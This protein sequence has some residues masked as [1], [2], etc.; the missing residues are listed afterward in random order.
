MLKFPFLRHV[1]VFSCEISLVCRL[2][3]P[4]N[5]CSS[6]FCFLVIALIIY[7]TPWEFFRSA[8]TD[9]F[10]WSLSDSTSH[11][12]S[13]TLLSI[14]ADLNNAVIW[15]VSTCPIIYESLYIKWLIFSCDLLSLYPAVHFLWMWLSGV[16]AITNSNGDS[17]SPWNMLL[18]IFTSAKLFPPAVKNWLLLLFLLFCTL[19]VFHNCV[20][21]GI[22][23]DFDWQQVSSGF[24]DFSL[25]SD[26][27]RYGLDNLDS[28]LIYSFS[29]PLSQPLG[30]IPS[31]LIIIGIIVTLM[32]HSNFFLV[33]CQYFCFLLFSL[34][35]L[36]E[37]QNP[38]DNNFFFVYL[39]WGL[40][41]WPGLSDLFVY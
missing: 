26:R 38:Q 29:S 23:W 34:S 13:K 3:Y 31:A 19:R 18:W 33:F 1:K 5:C 15:T 27:S 32:A 14:L 28:S 7:F 2:K 16:I 25:Y 22:L 20:T 11:Q 35:G 9:I 12:V 8:L 17:A 36:L 40:V 10:P 6:H 41:F 39:P 30:T 4:Y 24:Q 21:G 37:R